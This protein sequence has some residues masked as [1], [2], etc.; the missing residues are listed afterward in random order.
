MDPTADLQTWQEA[1]EKHPISATRAIER[2]LRASVAS[3]RD[4]LRSLVGGNYRELLSTAEQIVALDGQT[5]AAESHISEIGQRCKPPPQQRQTDRDTPCKMT[6][7]QLRLLQRCTTAAKSAVSKGDLLQAAQLI[8]VSRLL[9]KSLSNGNSPLR[10]IDCLREKTA[11]IRRQLLRRVDT[12]LASPYSKV[13]AIVNASCAYCLATSASFQD[14]F[15]HIQRLR[16]DRLRKSLS[17]TALI[18]QHVVDALRYYVASLRLMAGLTGRTMNDALGNLQK[19]PILQEPSIVELD[20]LDLKGFGALIPEEIESFIPYFKR[21]PF[22]TSGI[23]ENL[24]EWS[25][26]ACPVIAGGLERLLSE[27]TSIDSILAIRKSLFATLLPFHFSLPGSTS[28]HETLNRVLSQ[29]VEELCMAHIKEL[30]NL[31]ADISVSV[32][33]EPKTKDLWQEDVARMSLINGAASFLHQ[34]HR[35][36]RGTSSRLSRTS[37]SLTSWI[38]SM[39]DVQNAFHGLRKMRWRDMLEEPDD[40]QEAEGD[41]I[42]RGLTIDDPMRY[43]T[44]LERALERG[45]D[46]LEGAMVQTITRSL[47]QEAAGTVAVEYLRAIRETVLPL[48]QSLALHAKFKKLDE[49]IPRLHEVIATEVVSIVCTSDKQNDSAEQQSSGS[50]IDNLPSPRTFG[51]LRR[52]CMTMFELG[53]TD[54]WSPSAVKALKAKVAQEVFVEERKQAYIESSFDEEYLNVALNYTATSQDGASGPQKAAKEYWIRTKLLFGA[55]S[56][57]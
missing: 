52:I 49:L 40:E 41:A 22:S 32:I 35:R 39:K 25:S 37:R 5:R 31:A 34:V 46:D 13:P 50:M 11:S 6:V 54:I 1:F 48:R 20:I 28:M 4:R 51:F 36:R 33:T 3:N 26:D 15:K 24:I 47:D 8:V 2:Q 16:L 17:H 9:L 30:R 56:E 53:G 14:V 38:A 29:R 55:L 27:Q 12:T 44:Q 42:V 18:D 21:S 7:A 43:S 45:L 10:S 57:E 19:R 23:R